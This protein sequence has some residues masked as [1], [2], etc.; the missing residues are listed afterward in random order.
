MQSRIISG[1]IAVVYLSVAF[2]EGGGETA[3]KVAFF[4]ILPLALIWYSEPL[5]DYTGPTG[6]GPAITKATPGCVVAFVGWLLLLT[7]TIL[8]V[9]SRIMGYESQL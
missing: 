7:P 4:L 5:G 2:F 9:V 3:A 6:R 8:V 1:V